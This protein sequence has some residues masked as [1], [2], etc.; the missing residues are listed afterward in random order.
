M[1]LLPVITIV[2]LSAATAFSDDLKLLKPGSIAFTSCNTD[3]D[4]FSFV[5]LENLSPGTEIRFTDEEWNGSEFGTE[6]DDLVWTSTAELKAGTVISIYNC[7]AST[8][9]SN[10]TGTVRGFLRLSQSG[11]NIF[12]YGGN[13]E[14]QPEV[15][16]AALCTAEVELRGTGLVYGQ[17]AVLLPQTPK[18]L[19]YTGKRSGEKS[20]DYCLLIWQRRS[21]TIFFLARM[22]V[23]SARWPSKDST[24]RLCFK[25]QPILL[26]R[27]CC[28]PTAEHLMSLTMVSRPLIT[29][30]KSSMS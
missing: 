1:K 7:D 13:S 8:L 15:F 18:G 3:G 6:E 9:I 2:A 17:S 27:N 19:C 25:K 5:A 24:K 12:A 23:S 30:I 16:Y 11:E 22:S 20:S 4:S 21:S 26:A 29:E 14:R 28:N 10:N